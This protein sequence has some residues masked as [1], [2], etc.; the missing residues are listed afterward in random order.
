M[1]LS[2]PPPPNEKEMAEM[3][4]IVTDRSDKTKNSRRRDQLARLPNNVMM[5]IKHSFL[6]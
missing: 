4:R 5:I 2:S 3:L 1:S 6:I